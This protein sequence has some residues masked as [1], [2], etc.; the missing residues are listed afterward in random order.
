MPLFH[1]SALTKY[2]AFRLCLT[3]A[4]FPF[5]AHAVSDGAPVEDT[6]PA[7]AVPEEISADAKQE[8]DKAPPAPV[9]VAGVTPDSKADA[10][11]LPREDVRNPFL[12]KIAEEP[13][14]AAVIAGG[15]SVS[16]DTATAA[17][18]TPEGAAGTEDPAERDPLLR[19]SVAEI[20][21]IGTVSAPH[22]RIAAVRTRSGYKTLIRKGDI[23]GVENYV[24]S[25]VDKKGI[26]LT[27]DD[28]VIHIPVH[29]P[30]IED[31][32]ADER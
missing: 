22:D 18:A 24:V 12:R 3:A 6:P 23:A 11:I 29:N 4:L 32:Y 15:G 16:G 13:S 20:F 28:K 26:E 31:I 17:G 7:A 21:V 10:A 19:S 14:P 9:A 1:A 2:A 25:A 8:A 27:K 5:S 30:A